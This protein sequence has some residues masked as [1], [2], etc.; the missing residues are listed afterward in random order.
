[1]NRGDDL[2][3]LFEFVSKSTFDEGAFSRPIIKHGQNPSVSSSVSLSAPEIIG[4]LGGVYTRPSTALSM[5][6]VSS[7]A[8]DT[9][10]GTGANIILV[11]GVDN[12]WNEIY[13][14]VNMNGTSEV[15]L[16]NSYLRINFV[17]VVFSGSGQRNAG[18]IS[19]ANS[20]TTY[21]YITALE[22][23]DHTLHYSVPAGYT[24]FI[25][26][27]RFD[28]TRSAS[29]NAEIAPMAYQPATNTITAGTRINVYASAGETILDNSGLKLARVP[30]KTDIWYD[31]VY[32]SANGSLIGGTFRGIL[33]K[34]VY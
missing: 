21:G 16:L 8:N 32:C 22:S 28:V 18:N 2:R 15:T 30:E 34:E 27:S 1:M 33:V 20:G 19:V 23:L 6:I 7:D 17:R 26:A 4:D 31:A 24:L 9:L 5:T 11:E 29:T 14:L 25:S 12:D 3:G 13:E 10:G